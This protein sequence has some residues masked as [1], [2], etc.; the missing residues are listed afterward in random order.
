MH[1]GVTHTQGTDEGPLERPNY[2]D[3]YEEHE[4]VIDLDTDTDS[5]C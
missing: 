3:P 1:S 5:S 2:A 4:L